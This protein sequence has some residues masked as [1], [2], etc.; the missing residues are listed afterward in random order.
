[1]C[2]IY[3]PEISPSDTLLVD[4]K[5]SKFTRSIIYRNNI[6]KNDK[7]ILMGFLINGEPLN[8]KTSYFNE[9]KSYYEDIKK[10]FQRLGLSI[11]EKDGIQHYKTFENE[12]FVVK[13]IKIEEA[14]KYLKE[15]IKEF[16]MNN[17]DNKIFHETFLSIVNNH[18]NTFYNKKKFS[19]LNLVIVKFKEINNENNFN[20]LELLY[21]IPED[22]LIIIPTAHELSNNGYDYFVSG[23]ADNIKNIFAEQFKNFSKGNKEYL[24]NKEI[25]DKNTY[26]YIFSIYSDYEFQKNK[27]FNIP[28]YMSPYNINGFS[29]NNNIFYMLLND[30][31]NIN[32]FN[33]YLEIL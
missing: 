23:Y 9:Y 14:E 32:N 7:K 17:K 31:N 28:L 2:I 13:T 21:E 33:F 10:E 29:K 6:K 18:Q 11:L 27:N 20:T 1:M 8:I 4:R 5:L 26:S 12:N 30:Y 16:N 24:V 25:I 15:L 19:N 22:K 3:P